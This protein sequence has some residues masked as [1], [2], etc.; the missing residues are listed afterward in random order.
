MWVLFPILSLL[1]TLSSK[2]KHQF[3]GNDHRFLI[4]NE[5]QE[6][7]LFKE[8]ERIRVLFTKKENLDKLESNHIS[9]ITK[10]ALAKQVLG[11]D[12]LRIGNIKC[13]IRTEFNLD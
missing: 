2:L 1:L 12:H 10:T 5:E 4:S 9:L 13:G 8:R 11:A 3:D 6:Q 7:T